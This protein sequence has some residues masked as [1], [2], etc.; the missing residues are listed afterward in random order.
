MSRPFKR[1]SSQKLSALLSQ[2]VF[3]RITHSYLKKLNKE[4]VS[5]TYLFGEVYINFHHRYNHT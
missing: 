5:K 3:R 4:V 2:C 1:V